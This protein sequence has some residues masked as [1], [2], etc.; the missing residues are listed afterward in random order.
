MSD[1]QDCKQPVRF[2]LLGTNEDGSNK[3]SPPLDSQSRSVKETQGKQPFA[4]TGYVQTEVFTFHN[5]PE[6]EAAQAERFKRAQAR[7]ARARTTDE[8]WDEALKRIC[9]KCRAV[10][11]KRCLNLTDVRLGY[12]ANE[13]RETR[14]PHAE[15]LPVGWYTDHPVEV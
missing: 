3:W 4:R 15:R 5:C 12:P 1:C 13:V 14:H 7:E 11:G 10:D 6:R 9:P 2:V 8:A